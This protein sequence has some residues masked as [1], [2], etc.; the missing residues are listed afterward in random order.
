MTLA[1]ESGK[2]M[3]TRVLPGRPGD[4]GGPTVN[5]KRPGVGP[6]PPLAGA[7]ARVP[8]MQPPVRGTPPPP[9]GHLC[10]AR[11]S[12]FPHST[13]VSCVCV[14]QINSPTPPPGKTV[15][16]LF[17]GL[18]IV[19]RCPLTCECTE[20]PVPPPANPSQSKSMFLDWIHS[21]TAL[22]LSCERLSKNFPGPSGNDSPPDKNPC[23]VW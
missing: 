10:R 4:V 5:G 11:L 23:G 18:G 13:C 21:M 12:A 7:Y 3:V 20:L 9:T 15:I 8:Y 19:A 1:R 14:V 6:R 17:L 16:V 2:R 22:L